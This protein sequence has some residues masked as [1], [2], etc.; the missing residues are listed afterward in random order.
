MYT[1]LLTQ[2]LALLHVYAID[3]KAYCPRMVLKVFDGYAPIGECRVDQAS[4]HVRRDYSGSHTQ[5]NVR[6]FLASKA[7]KMYV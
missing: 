5:T 6:V 3:M 4:V 7:F 2:C 1:V